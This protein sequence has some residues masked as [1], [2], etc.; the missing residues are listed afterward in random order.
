MGKCPI[1]GSPVR[2]AGRTTKYYEPIQ[3]SRRY[4]ALEAVAAAAD[5][6]AQTATPDRSAPN[7]AYECG[8]E[9]YSFWTG[10]FDQLDQA[11]AALEVE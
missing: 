7:P 9:C 1:C 6:I 11:L 3:S 5:N 8:Y 4:A 2:V 10:F